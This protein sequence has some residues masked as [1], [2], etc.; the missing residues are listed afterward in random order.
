[1]EHRKSTRALCLLTMWMQWKHRNNIVFKGTTPSLPGVL[2]M[3]QEEGA[4]WVKVGLLNGAVLGEGLALVE[5]VGH[6]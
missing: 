4:L 3:L 6:E 5:L 2:H 1:M